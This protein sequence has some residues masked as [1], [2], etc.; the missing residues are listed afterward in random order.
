MSAPSP[1]PSAQTA[2]REFVTFGP[3]QLNVVDRD[4]SV[5]WWRDVA[6]LQVL[7]EHDGSVQ[8]GAGGETLVVLRG[9]AVSPVRR[10]YSGLY[11]L[12]IY[13]PSEAELARAL[14][15]VRQSHELMGATD[16]AVAKSI[17]V[18]DPDG[19]GL[20]IAIET[21]E[22][23]RSVRWAE[24]E[25]EPEIVD[26]QGRWRGGVE[27]LDVELLLRALTDDDFARPLPPGTKVGHVNLHVPDLS[28][29]YSFYRDRLGFLQSNYAPLV[30]FGDLSAGIPLTHRIAVNTWQGEGA[31][32]RPA[33]TAG[34]DHFTLRFDS[35]Q[36][37]EQVLA[38]LE[39]VERQ[40]DG[41]LAHDPAG[42][43][44]LLSA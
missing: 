8:L 34:M 33:G 4:R 3:V 13:P 43:A 26:A 40:G 17:Y 36:R 18:N 32:P 39:G 6:G 31:P 10:G 29:A 23:V 7:E 2:Q 37:L 28:E 44:M 1:Q 12:A 25:T 42:N 21:P 11:H 35:R 41:Y 14:A 19:I 5:A 30:G 38:R 22:R 9:D 20:E 27:P 24:T 16:H 15:R